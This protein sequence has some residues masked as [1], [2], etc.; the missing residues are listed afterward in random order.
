[1]LNSV[2]QNCKSQPF[3]KLVTQTLTT[4]FKDYFVKEK[5][6]GWRQKGILGDWWRDACTG[7]GFSIGILHA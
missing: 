6:S 2:H 4:D 5:E 3:F 7:S 1:M